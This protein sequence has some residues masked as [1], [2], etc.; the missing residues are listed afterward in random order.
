MKKPETK[1]L[2]LGLA[3]G[4]RAIVEQIIP[5]IFMCLYLDPKRQWQQ[6]YSFYRIPLN[7]R[8]LC[9]VLLQKFENNAICKP[10]INN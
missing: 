7:I 10:L 6:A 9:P 2:F 5:L 3:T 1:G 4:D 8:Y